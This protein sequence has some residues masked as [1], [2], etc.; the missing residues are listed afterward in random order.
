[1]RGFV[2]EVGP[3]HIFA[4]ISIHYQSDIKELDAGK[5]SYVWLSLTRVHIVFLRLQGPPLEFVVFTK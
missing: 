1:M 3:N 4:L 2:Y 5:G